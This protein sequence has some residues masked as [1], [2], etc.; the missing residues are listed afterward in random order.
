MACGNGFTS[1]STATDAGPGA[2]VSTQDVATGPTDSSSAGDDSMADSSSPPESGLVDSP[3]IVGDGGASYCAMHVGTYDFC[4]DFDRFANVTAFLGSWTTFSQTGGTFAFDQNDVPSAPN[5]LV[6]TTNSTSG[7]RTLVI[8]VMPPA[9]AP[10][11]K[12]RLEFDF[13]VDQ[14]SNVGATAVGA[15]AAILYGGDVTGGA[16]A[17]GFGNGTG[18]SATLAAMYLGPTPAGGGLP[19]FNSANAPPPFPSLAVWDGRFA[20]EITYPPPDAGSTAGDT[21]CAQLYIG[22][23]AQLSPCLSLPTS[24]SHPAQTTSIALGVFSGGVGSSGNIGVAFDNVTFIG[25]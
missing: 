21:A 5:A 1:S 12:Q 23:I 18:S 25:Q 8:H 19:V 2:D 7:V 17:L 3:I 4:E 10:V 22:S 11:A 15:V 14:A 6:A 24:L 16:V 9:T 20:I 13:L